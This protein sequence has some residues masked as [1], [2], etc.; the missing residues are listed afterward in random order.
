MIEAIKGQ[1]TIAEMESEFETH[2]TQINTRKKQLL[3]R[4]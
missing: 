1:K 4:A 3:A 2:L